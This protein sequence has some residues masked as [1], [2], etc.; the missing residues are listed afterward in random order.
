MFPYRVQAGILEMLGESKL[1]GAKCKTI[2]DACKRRHVDKH[3][4]HASRV[5]SETSSWEDRWILFM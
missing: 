3:A 5:D 4:S 2:S 1:Q